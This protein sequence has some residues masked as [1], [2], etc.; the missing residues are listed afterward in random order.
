[1]V[2]VLYPQTPAAKV[3]T[4]FRLMSLIPC[5]TQW[6][7]HTPPHTYIV[8]M[9][10]NSLVLHYELSCPIIGSLPERRSYVQL[11]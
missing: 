2:S 10:T 5:K 8:P 7:A 9:A 11:N 4:L 1:M 3:A 6:A